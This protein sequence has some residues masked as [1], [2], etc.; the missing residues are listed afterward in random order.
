MRLG[1]AKENTL[2]MLRNCLV[3]VVPYVLVVQLMHAQ[4]TAIPDENFEVA[5]IALGLDAGEPDGQVLTADIAE[6]DD[7]NVNDAGISN[8]TGLAGFVR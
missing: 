5:L 3:I 1:C 4:Y 7:L 2:Q 8:L 6:V